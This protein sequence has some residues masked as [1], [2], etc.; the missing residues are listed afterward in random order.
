M[1][2]THSAYDVAADIG[3]KIDRGEWSD[4]HRLPPERALA[5]QYGLARNTVRSALKLL[6]DQG[7]LVRWVGRGTFVRAELAGEGGH[8]GLLHNMR[9]ASPSDVMEVRLIIEPQA[10]ALAASRASAEDL[11]EIE[12]ALRQSVSAKGIAQFEHWDSKLHLAIFRA[13]KN[14]LLS[15]YCEAI[16]AVRNQ[17]R[18]YRLKQRTLKPEYRVVYDQQHSAVVTAL[19]DR[20]GDA[21][22]R[23][24][25][26]HLVTVR[27]N[28]FGSDSEDGSLV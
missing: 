5:A 18:W 19:K 8:R 4:G 3:G 21:A 26:Q 27:D 20:D 15:D 11:A 22:R 10:A 23:A 24:L 1:D 25:Q 9:E 13:A 7:R 2:E 16:N 14:A 17:P 12:E 6:E 28:L